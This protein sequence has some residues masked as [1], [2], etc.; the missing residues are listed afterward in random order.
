[1][2]RGAATRTAVEA[3]AAAEDAGGDAGAGGRLGERLVQSGQVAADTMEDLVWERHAR[4]VWGLLTWD[5][6]DFRVVAL[7]DPDLAGA[8]PIE[9]PLP[10]TALLL[11]ELQRAEAARS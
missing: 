7:D 9:P 10:V 1:V 2:A 4:V 6:G 8:R 11:D 3:A 5:R